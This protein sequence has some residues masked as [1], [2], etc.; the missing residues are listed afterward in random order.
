M[1]ERRT[2]AGIQETINT[3]YFTPHYP[4]LYALH[5]DD[6]RLRLEER[7]S[8]AGFIMN[9][10]Y[11]MGPCGVSQLQCTMHPPLID[12]NYTLGTTLLKCARGEV[13]Y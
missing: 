3:K 11:I 13:A 12:N 7:I 6:A 8:D 5:D 4:C 9:R 1:H 2:G 10:S